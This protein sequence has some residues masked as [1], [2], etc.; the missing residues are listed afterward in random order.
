MNLTQTVIA[1]FAVPHSSL[2]TILKELA[3]AEQ[4]N[5]QL[6]KNVIVTQLKQNPAPQP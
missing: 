3:K 4:L 6:S 5:H 1:F 2:V